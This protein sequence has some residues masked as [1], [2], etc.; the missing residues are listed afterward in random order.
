MTVVSDALQSDSILNIKYG[1]SGERTTG[2]HEPVSESSDGSKVELHFKSAIFL[3]RPVLDPC[4][5]VG[6]L[7]FPSDC[8]RVGQLVRMEWRVE[9]LKETE[10]LSSTGNVSLA[11]ATLIFNVLCKFNLLTPISPM[12][13]QIKSTHSYK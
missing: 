10:S 1:I 11:E 13:S 6:F 2:A 4:L 9:R 8:L 5:A 7:P 3:Q 12:C